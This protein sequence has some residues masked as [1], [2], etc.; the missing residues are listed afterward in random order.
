MRRRF[1]KDD[2]SDD[3]EFSDVG[4]EALNLI[5]ALMPNCPIWQLL[6]SGAGEREQRE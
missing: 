3:W 5:R 2:F 6:P 1:R 4:Q